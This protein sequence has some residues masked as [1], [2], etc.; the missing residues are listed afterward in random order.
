MISEQ[1][2]VGAFGEGTSRSDELSE[3]LGLNVYDFGARNYDPALG[4]WMNID[5]LAEGMRRFSP[6]N[7]AFNNPVVFVDPDGMAPWGFDSYGRDLA[8]SGAIASWS[9]GNDY[10]DGFVAKQDKV[11][12]VNKESAEKIHQDMNTVFADK[13]FDSF[14][15]LL[16]RGKKNNNTTF[17]EISEDA[18][19]NATSGLSGNDLDAVTS[20]YNAINSKREFVFEYMSEDTMTTEGNIAYKYHFN[21]NSTNI[22][23]T[24]DII[25]LG[26]EG[27]T[28]SS[29]KGIH[30]FIVNKSNTQHLEGKR[31]LTAFH[32][33]FG[34][35]I[36]LNK[37]VKDSNNNFNSIRYENMIREVM[38]IK[39]KR[40]GT[41]P[42]HN[43]GKVPNHL[44]K[45]L[46]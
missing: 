20:I 8:K 27:L 34:H 9:T 21:D 38:L 26:G 13:R 36:P 3:E 7:Y 40:D 12:G 30:A 41:N 43:G 42:F 24:N 18:F 25:A 15:A 28:V 11:K 35:G 29:K 1:K 22:Y 31:S 10:W 6:Y 45:P 16:T 2:A 44:S 19:K 14:R 4:R 32:E 17:D 46:L 33:G 37:G 39:M 23:T 5:P